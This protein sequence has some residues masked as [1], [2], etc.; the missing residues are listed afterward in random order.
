MAAN[1][2][3]RVVGLDG[4]RG[5]LATWVLGFHLLA[6]CGIS[7]PRV[8]DGSHAVDAFFALSGFVVALVIDVERLPYGWFL[9]KRLFRLFP[10][11][12][13]C[14]ALGAV[15]SQ[16]G[17]MP[18]R[19]DVGTDTSHVIAH[20]VMLHGLIPDSILRNSAGAFLNPAWSI[21]VEWQF[22][23]V[24]PAVSY[25]L[26]SGRR[27]FVWIALLIT[28]IVV[29][30]ASRWLTFNGNSLIGDGSL[31]RNIGPF[32]LGIVSFRAYDWCRRNRLKIG[33]GA[34]LL[35]AAGF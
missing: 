28:A 14:T 23:L 27:P 1:N 10:V 26:G 18:D 19:T 25:F 12:V 17:I 13:L 4:L 15:L 5:V 3:N 20:L 16:I 7:V 35:I 33:D 8:L 34:V 31:I 30:R 6:I 2:Q 11:F 24:A 9:L 22:Y 32:L 21:S 29:E